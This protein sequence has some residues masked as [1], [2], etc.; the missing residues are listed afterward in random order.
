MYFIISPNESI[1]TNLN[2]YIFQIYKGQNIALFNSISYSKLT[3]N[4]KLQRSVNGSYSNTFNFE[5]YIDNYAGIG[6]PLIFN[7]VEGTFYKNDETSSEKSGIIEINK[8]IIENNQLII[9]GN[10]RTEKSLG[11]FSYTDDVMDFVILL[12]INKLEDKLEKLIAY[13]D[14]LNLFINKKQ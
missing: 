12:E 9:S 1:S 3:C 6:I 14:M 4:L 8:Y 7:F 10:I 13:L 5:T 11:L 2:G